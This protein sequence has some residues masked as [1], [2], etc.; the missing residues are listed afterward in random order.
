MITILNE[1]I[2]SYSYTGPGFA[3][4]RI[5][6]AEFSGED[7]YGEFVKD[8]KTLYVNSAAYSIDSDYDFYREYSFKELDQAIRDFNHEADRFGDPFNLTYEDVKNILKQKN[9]N[10]DDYLPGG[11]YDQLRK[12]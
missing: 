3:D 5:T 2:N 6:I 7:G 8:G 11:F 4:D 1:D 12:R 9:I 10:V